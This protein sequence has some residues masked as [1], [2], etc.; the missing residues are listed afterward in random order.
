MGLHGDRVL[1]WMDGG[2]SKDGHR[3]ETEDCF[4]F[5]SPRAIWEKVSVYPAC[6]RMFPVSRKRLFI[7]FLCFLFYQVSVSSVLL[8]GCTYRHSSSGSPVVQFNSTG[9]S[10]LSTSAIRYDSKGKAKLTSNEKT[11][12]TPPSRCSNGLSVSPRNEHPFASVRVWFS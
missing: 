2:Y 10:F 7:R 3:T 12:I 5:L 11:H 4:A 6:G 9:D 8:M 1:E